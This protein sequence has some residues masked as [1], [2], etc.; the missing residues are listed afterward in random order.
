MVDVPALQ[1]L[2]VGADVKAPPLLLPQTP[3]TAIILFVKIPISPAE[4]VK[5]MTV[6]SAAMSPYMMTCE[7][8]CEDST[9][10]TRVTAPS[11]ESVAVPVMLIPV[12]LFVV[13]L[14]AVKETVNVPS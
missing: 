1:R 5:T 12:L 6:L 11:D 9:L 13:P 8:P 4:S 7:E 2:V 10:V 3:L 14:L